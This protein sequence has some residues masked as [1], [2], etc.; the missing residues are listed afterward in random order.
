[1]CLLA[2]SVRACVC[3]HAYMCVTGTPA[4]GDAVSPGECL[5]SLLLAKTSRN[6]LFH[7]LLSVLFVGSEWDLQCGVLPGL[8]RR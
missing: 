4:V 8:R 1:M 3:V 5:V 2:T 7:I 6:G